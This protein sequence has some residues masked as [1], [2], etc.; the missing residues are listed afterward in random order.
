LH[1]ESVG[2]DCPR[3]LRWL[4]AEV[5]AL[6]GRLAQARVARLSQ[7]APHFHVAI[8]ATGL[9]AR[10]LAGD[11]ACHAYRGRVIRVHA[12]H[13]RDFAT[14]TT[15][16]EERYT[17]NTYVLPRPTSGVVTCGGTYERDLEGLGADEEQRAA[18]WA[19]CVALV[20]ALLDPRTTLLHDWAGLRPGRDG[21]VRLEL[22]R[23]E[24]LAVV[25]AYGHGGCGHSLHH[26]TAEDVVA[27]ARRA[28]EGLDAREGKAWFEAAPPPP[29]N[30]E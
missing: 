26:G 22:E 23:V 27:L 19:R 13:V 9:G 1:Y 29:G 4:R 12:P 3:Y 10:E 20:P 14:A 18:I 2:V 5:E 11:P 25:H 21:D 6:G 28:M 17:M 30:Q 8:N 24:A 7:L 16:A 15:T